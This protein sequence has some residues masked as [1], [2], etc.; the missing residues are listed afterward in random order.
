[1]TVFLDVFVD[2][3]N[4]LSRVGISCIFDNEKRFIKLFPTVAVVDTMA[5][6]TMNG[7]CQFNAYYG[8]DWCLL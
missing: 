8:C 4:H 3:M 5:R 6:A 2:K 1:M 7:S